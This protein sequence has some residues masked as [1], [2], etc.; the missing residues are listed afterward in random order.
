MEQENDELQIE[1]NMEKMGYFVWKEE[2][3]TENRE[4]FLENIEKRKI[5]NYFFYEDEPSVEGFWE[6]FED[7]F[8]EWLEEE[9]NVQCDIEDTE[10]EYE[11]SQMRS[12]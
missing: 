7:E 12:L 8:N 11:Q 1:N 5:T 3:L 2:N 9:F 10:R 6:Y 4:L